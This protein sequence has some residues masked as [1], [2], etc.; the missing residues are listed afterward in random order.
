M[1]AL[2][3]IVNLAIG[4]VLYI[5]FIILGEK[6]E[7]KKEFAAANTMAHDSKVTNVKSEGV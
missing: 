4:V 2:L 5:P 1:G 7:N 3:S 6:H